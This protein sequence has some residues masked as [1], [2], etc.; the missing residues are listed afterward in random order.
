MV[1]RP[2]DRISRAEIINAI[3]AM[4]TGMTAGPSKVNFK[5][6]AASGQVREEVM[7][8]VYQRLLD[9][10]GIPDDWKT[11]MVVPIYKEKNV[12]KCRSCR[13]VK[14][15]E[16]GMK[17]VERLLGKKLRLMMDLNE[18]QFAFIPEKDTVDPLLVIRRLH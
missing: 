15:Q 13:G 18:T 4:K 12:L 3:K 8:K 1:K 9:S 10:N 6:I 2:L 16:H 14:L 17:I 5:M 7:R 11:S